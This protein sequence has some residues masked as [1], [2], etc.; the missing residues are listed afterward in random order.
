MHWHVKTKI[1]LATVA[2][3]L[4]SAN[5]GS[6]VF[7][8]P[9]SMPL[10]LHRPMDEDT[11]RM[12]RNASQ[13]ET[14]G[15][16][17]RALSLY[18]EL[19]D[20]FPE[21]NPFY[22]GAIRSFIAL[23]EFEEALGWVDALKDSMLSLARPADLTAFERERLGN[24]IVDGGRMVG[25][26][27]DR[28][29]ALERWEAVYD[30]PLTS[31]GPFFRLFNAMIEIRYPD[32]LE[33]MVKKAREASGNPS[34]L[35]S[36]LA[37]FFA[38]QGRVDRAIDEWL[39][40]MELQPRQAGSIKQRILGLPEDETTRDQI[41]TSL[42]EGLSRDAIR[43]QVVELL[44]S[45]YFRSRQWEEAYE[46]VKSAD[47]Q[48]GSSGL[49]TL[50]FAEK[51]VTEN[52]HVLA[53]RVLDDLQTS[54]PHLA[55][56]ARGVF[57]QA[58]ALQATGEFE[59]SDSVFSV[60]SLGPNL[61]T[62]QGQEALLLQAQMRLNQLK[63]PAQARELL[64][65]A[66]ERLPRMRNPGE[67]ILL[68][69]DSYL[70]ERKLAAA[71]ETYLEA[72]GGRYGR[73]PDLQARA[74]INAANVDFYSGEIA[75]AMERFQEAS[76]KSP[77]GL[78]TNDALD[79]LELLRGG[80]TDSVGLAQFARAAFEER[81]GNTAAA[82]SLYTSLLQTRH[83]GD[84]AERTLLKIA[85]IDRQAG[86]IEEALQSYN[87]ALEKFPKS[88]RAPQILLESGKIHQYD[89]ID[90]RGASQYYERILI[91][92]PNS[93]Q[94]DEARRLLRDLELPET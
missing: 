6:Q 35:A 7:D 21:Y 22:D 9:P 56:S 11:R 88:L 29:T 45:F 40:L 67:A 42:K 18:L 1:I 3:F 54:Y 65:G 17:E 37:N 23:G 85:Q 26:T 79:M 2:C 10:N 83:A 52:I 46:Q 50:I 84:I 82:E 4:I 49:A 90:P 55:N 30:I 71:L 32:G 33:D 28:E 61:G 80:S 86:R 13:L 74:L 16:F 60:L 66:L 73:Q 89:L 14:R 63:Q 20:R 47:Q 27:G 51:L 31:T 41:E 36:A 72:S 87:Q 39:R 53:R 15:E 59:Q 19:F 75:R 77:D 12:Q 76:R 48:G 68:I 93:L 94:V 24:Y 64:E 91:D 58:R 8:L 44:G 34:L 5:A 92:H 70:I 81:I 38:T 62:S 78:L 69:G 43:L 25:K 57:A